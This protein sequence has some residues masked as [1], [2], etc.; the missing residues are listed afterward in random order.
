MT[1]TRRTFLYLLAGLAVT[2]CASTTLRNAWFDPT[3]TGGPVL[4]GAMDR[5]SKV[6][7]RGHTGQ[8]PCNGRRVHYT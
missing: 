6:P 4:H 5:V 7:G 2:G 8:T 1:A 3:F